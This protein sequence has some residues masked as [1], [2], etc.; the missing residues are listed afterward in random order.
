MKKTTR[1]FT[2]IELLIV[3]AIIGILAGVILVSTSSARQR[4]KMA[5]FKSQATSL[6][7]A[8]IVEC[9]KSTPTLP[10]AWPDATTGSITT[11][12]TCASGVITGGVATAAAATGGNCTA[13]F[14]S[15][16]VTFNG[17]GC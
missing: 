7:S 10:I 2:L 6:N 12:A 11:A 8:L 16:G 5:N 9:D 4:A 17:T 15:T 3:I 1:G 13:A 14:G